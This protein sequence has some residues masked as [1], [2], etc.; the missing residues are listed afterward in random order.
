[1]LIA[2]AL[3]RAAGGGVLASDEME[4]PGIHNFHRATTHVFSGSQPEGEA[5][6]AALAKLGV[7]TILSV[8]GA[9]PEVALAAKHGLRYVHLPI[10]YDGITGNRV[11]ELAQAAAVLPGPIFVHCHHGLHRGPAA[12]AAICRATAGW[13]ATQATNFMHAAGTAPEY[14]GLY[15]AVHE[16]TMPSPAQL[17]AVDTNFP[18]VAKTTALVD[19]M[20]VIDAHFDRLKA[21]DRAGW[22]SA[23]AA[24]PG[25][26]AR[27]ALLLLEQLRELARSNDTKQ[28]PED[29]RVLLDESRAAAEV[30]NAQLAA[31]ASP[32]EA[33]NQLRQSCNDCHR[34]YRNE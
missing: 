6:F 32:G 14:A 8:D 16:L 7:K 34:R 26:N 27:E 3:F 17:A 18:A 22:R 9:K 31:A 19:A 23:P 25:A 5:A 2:V 21:A 10:G 4:L 12:V 13:D 30:V 15:R 33:F 24:S 28:R 29:Y 11:A 1:M 20:V